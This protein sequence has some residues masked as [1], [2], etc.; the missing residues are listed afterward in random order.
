MRCFRTIEERPLPRNLHTHQPYDKTQ[1]RQTETVS[2]VGSAQR[3]T[4][5]ARSQLRKCRT[6]SRASGR[7]PTR[8][9]MAKLHHR[10]QFLS[11]SPKSLETAEEVE[12]KHHWMQGSIASD[13]FLFSY[14]T[15]GSNR[16]SHRSLRPLQKSL[17]VSFRVSSGKYRRWL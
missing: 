11:N 3:R 6:V 1:T 4:G 17:F 5:A 15:F 7:S 8:F 16:T 2:R 13:N 10:H 12:G 14:S 9:A